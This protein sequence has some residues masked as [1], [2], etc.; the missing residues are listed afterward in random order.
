MGHVDIDDPFFRVVLCHVQIR[1]LLR[2]ATRRGFASDARSSDLGLEVDEWMRRQMTD[3]SWYFVCGRCEAKW[4]APQPEVACPR[5]R[6]HCV[7]RERLVPPWSRLQV[8]SMPQTEPSM[9]SNVRSVNNRRAADDVTLITAQQLAGCLQVSKRSLWRLRTAGQLPEPVRLGSSALATLGH[10]GLARRQ[11]PGR[12][13][14][15]F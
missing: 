10:Q 9:S 13:G 5:C 12:W 11:M 1:G 2:T 14:P 3:L 7:S 4:F 8:S 6:Q 15:R